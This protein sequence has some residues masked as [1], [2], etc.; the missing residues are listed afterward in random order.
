[1]AFQAAIQGWT[2]RYKLTES[3]VASGPRWKKIGGE[4]VV[5]NVG[6]SSSSPRIGAKIQKNHWNHHLDDMGVSKNRGK[7]SKMD[8]ENNGKP[9]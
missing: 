6:G 8:G 9:Y 5:K 1:M 2:S 3:W 7:T 4:M